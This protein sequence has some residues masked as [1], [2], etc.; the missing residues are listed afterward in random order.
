M[1]YYLIVIEGVTIP[2]KLTLI[3]VQTIEHWLHG[4]LR[5]SVL[6]VE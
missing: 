1:K 6:E 5:T 4:I 2:K 3:Q